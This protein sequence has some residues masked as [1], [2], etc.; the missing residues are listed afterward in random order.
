[1]RI[2]E[3]LLQQGYPSM[4]TWDSNTI[5]GRVVR[6]CTPGTKVGITA[7]KRLCQGMSK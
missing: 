4:E 1:M 7:L 2:C 3:L 5:L 6:Q